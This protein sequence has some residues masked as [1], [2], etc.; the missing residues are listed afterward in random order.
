MGRE[1]PKKQ[2]AD[3]VAEAV[4]IAKAIEPYGVCPEHA[5][6]R[7]ILDDFA[8]EG[9]SSSG[10][11]VFSGSSHALEYSLSTKPRVESVAVLKY[12]GDSKK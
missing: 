5:R 9:V 7:K 4:R 6:A 3:R 1:K 8:R 10:R 12:V 11:I 2:M